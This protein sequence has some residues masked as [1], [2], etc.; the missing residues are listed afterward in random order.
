MDLDYSLQRLG[1]TGCPGTTLSLT[2]LGA[3]PEPWFFSNEI[4]YSVTHVVFYTTDFGARPHALDP[5]AR[6]YLEV[7]IPVWLRILEENENWDLTA[8]LSM[9]AD[10]IR[11]EM[12]DDPLLNL[13]RHQHRTGYIPGPSTA[14]AALVRPDDDIE[15]VAF[16]ANYHTTLVSLMA[17]GS[18]AQF[19]ER[20]S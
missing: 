19:R 12:E 5:E 8:E 20:S 4:G 18:A 14:G 11:L 10:C 16:L 7:W 1:I 17:L 9:V 6:A 2:W 3:C 15:R 13:T